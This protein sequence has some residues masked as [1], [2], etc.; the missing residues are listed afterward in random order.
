MSFRSIIIKSIVA[1]ATLI[2]VACT[3]PKNI[4]YMQ[5]FDNNN[6]QA[7][8]H[9]GDI[10]FKPG[11]QLSILVSSKDAVL[12][13]VFNLSIPTRRIGQTSGS[14]IKGSTSSN[15][16]AT[17]IYTIDPSGDIN[18]PVLGEI[19]IA[20]MTRSE[21][22][23]YIEKRLISGNYLKD[24]VVTVEFENMSV[25]ILGEVKSPG[26][27]AIAKDNLNI[28]QAISMAGDLTIDGRRENVL[29]VRKENGIEKAYRL[30]LTDTESIFDS[31]AFYLQQDDIVYIEPN[32]KAQRQ[33]TVNGNSLLTPSFWMSAG[34]FLL[35]IIL[36]IAK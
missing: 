33:S 10:K 2:S 35:S 22:S 11:D 24:P 8:E 1:A 13:E 32:N 14:D 6:V 21:L 9:Q 16:N 3:T 20:G 30:N 18:F 4:V 36:L 19:H 28:L 31:P 34:S 26:R 15:N 17:G 29:I 12:A 23:S 7:I 25:A 5:G 27:Y